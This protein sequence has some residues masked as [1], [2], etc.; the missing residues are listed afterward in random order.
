MAR[1][2]SEVMSRRQARGVLA[3]GDALILAVMRWPASDQL[4]GDDSSC[5]GPAL[6]GSSG[7]TRTAVVRSLEPAWVGRPAGMHSC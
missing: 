7:S 4:I 3:R 5:G 1:L 2:V 6:P